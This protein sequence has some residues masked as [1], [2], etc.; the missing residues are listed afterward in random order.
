M[1]ISSF[2]TLC[3]SIFFLSICTLMNF[4]QLYNSHIFFITVA[5]SIISWKRNPTL[6][7]LQ[8]QTPTISYA[9]IVKVIFFQNSLVKSKSNKYYIFSLPLEYM[10]DND[11]EEIANTIKGSDRTLYCFFSNLIIHREEEL[12]LTFLENNKKKIPNTKEKKTNTLLP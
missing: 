12:L 3:N 1:M 4:N 6:V 5:D 2:L 9:Q 11:F 8:L 7:R 10:R